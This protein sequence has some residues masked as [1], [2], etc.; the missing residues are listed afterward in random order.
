MA[1]D[2]GLVSVCVLLGLSAASDVINH[3]ILLE[4]LK[5]QVGMKGTALDWFKS[6]ISDKYQFVHVNNCLFVH[7]IDNHGVPQGSV[8]GPALFTLYSPGHYHQETL[9]KLN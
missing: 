6:Y 1:S 7:T 5:N 4:R 9:H 2:Q 3:Q 8:L